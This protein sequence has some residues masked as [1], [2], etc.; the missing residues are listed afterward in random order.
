MCSRI[1]N[2]CVICDYAFVWNVWLLKMSCE[3]FVFC[4]DLCVLIV[5][6]A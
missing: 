3:S 5:N 2:L 6:D 1:I 4:V